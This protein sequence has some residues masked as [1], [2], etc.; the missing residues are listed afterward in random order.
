MPTVLSTKKLTVSQKQLILNAG[1]GFVEY[2]AIQ[3]KL[4]ALPT[5]ANH[6]KNLIFTSKNAVKAVIN[7]SR[8]EQLSTSHIFCVGEKTA[9]L[10]ENYG[11]RVKE[12]QPYGEQLANVIVNEYS[13]RSFTYFCGSLRREELP[14]ILQQH[15]VKFEEV[16]VYTTT[17]NKKRFGQ[18]FDAILFYSPS[19]VESFCAKNN[20][21]ESLAICIGNTTATE[22]RK[23]SQNIISATTPSIENVIVQAVKLLKLPAAGKNQEKI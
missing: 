16:E 20:L 17:L 11:Y 19:G 7:S 15:Q 5:E 14:G 12:I 23:H 2:N 21:G 13:N 6:Q 22:A 1:L 8:F 18:Q 10:L 9:E 3:V 4:R